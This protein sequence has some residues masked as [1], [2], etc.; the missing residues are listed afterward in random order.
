ML[1]ANR[2]AGRSLRTKHKSEGQCVQL[3][4]YSW[5]NKKVIN[6]NGRQLHCRP[7]V[8]FLLRKH[9]NAVDILGIDH[10]HTTVSE[11]HLGELALLDRIG[12]DSLKGALITISKMNDLRNGLTFCFD[13]GFQVHA[14]S[15]AF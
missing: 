9:L 7:F 14:D 13:S 12:L 10:K 8:L 5:R 3:H 15:I 1:L 6:T 2:R 11:L 4:S